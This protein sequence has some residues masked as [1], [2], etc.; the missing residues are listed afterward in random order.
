MRILIE[1]RGTSEMIYQR[2]EKIQLNQHDSH[3]QLSQKPSRTIRQSLSR[4]SVK[5]NRPLS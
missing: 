3:D 1:L 5:Q 2:G 4:L